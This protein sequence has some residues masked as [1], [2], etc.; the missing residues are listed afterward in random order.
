MF[1]QFCS[2]SKKLFT[3]RTFCNLELVLAH[4]W[5][6]RFSIVIVLIV[7]LQSFDSACKRHSLFRGGRINLVIL[8]SFGSFRVF[9]R[10]FLILL[11]IRT[12][13]GISYSA[14]SRDLLRL[15]WIFPCLHARLIRVCAL[16]HFLLFFQ[17]LLKLC[18]FCGLLQTLLHLF[19][20]EL[21]TLRAPLALTRFSRCFWFAC[22]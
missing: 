19:F 17:V 22:F 3:P 16:S 9:L 5:I 2:C 18:T 1:T 10:I 15:M 20:S 13:G 8:T 12:F 14:V 6:F 11:V 21:R 7:T 4:R